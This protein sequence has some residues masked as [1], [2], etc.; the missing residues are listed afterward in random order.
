MKNNK[1]Y[2]NLLEEADYWSKKGV[3]DREI[4]ES[5]LD[6]ITGFGGSVGEGFLETIK[7]YVGK[8]IIAKFN[9]DPNSPMALVL[10]NAF[11]NL[12]FQDYKKVFRDCDFTS[13]LIAESVIDAVIENFRSKAGYDSPI[14]S[15]VQD[16][17][18][19]ILKKN[20]SIETLAQKMSGTICPMLG[21]TREMIVGEIPFLDKFI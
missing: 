3:S 10:V 18:V 6:A 21:S 13:R 16:T 1:L 14:Y 20:D 11:A 7:K 9:L 15:V 2:R 8:L 5:M 17:M 19:D 4:D 12:S